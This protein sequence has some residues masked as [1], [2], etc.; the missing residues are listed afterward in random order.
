MFD[1]LLGTDCMHSERGNG[2]EIRCVSPSNNVKVGEDDEGESSNCSPLTRDLTKCI[3]AS[4]WPF[5]AWIERTVIRRTGQQVLE[6]R[7]TA[8]DLR[9]GKRRIFNEGK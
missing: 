9:R 5:W 2:S 1:R 7:L 3:P 8:D 4:C 6:G